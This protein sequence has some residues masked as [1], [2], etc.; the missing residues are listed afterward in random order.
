MVEEDGSQS[1]RRRAEEK[2]KKERKYRGGLDRADTYGSR[3]TVLPAGLLLLW[4]AF[5]GCRPWDQ[6]ATRITFE[7][8]SVEKKERVRE[9]ERGERR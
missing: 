7:R 3:I 8:I 1:R 2:R 6:H 4:F 9:R 5:A